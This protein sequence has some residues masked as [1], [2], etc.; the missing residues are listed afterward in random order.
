[1]NPFDVVADFES[2]MAEFT[3][4]PYA[5]AVDSC[6]S[7]LFLSMKY[8]FDKGNYCLNGSDLPTIDIPKRTFISVPQ[9][10][11]ESGYEK[12]KF[13]DFIWNGWYWL[14]PLP[15]IDSALHLKRDMWK[16]FMVFR[17][18]EPTFRGKPNPY[19]GGLTYACLSFQYRKH[20]PIGRGGMILHNDPEADVWFR[21]AR[22]YGRQACP[23]E[24]DSGPVFLGWR[25]YMTPDEAARGLCFM[26]TFPDNEPD[27][28]IKYP[29]LSGIPAFQPYVT[30]GERQ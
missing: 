25:K 6:T 9:Q 19:P 15:I 14:K 11:I 10:A 8:Q 28:E 1:M 17:D 13:V 21:L 5:V 3:G 22:F 20:I 16:E 26:H 29:P 7:A 4:A 18:D 24:D 2:C 12:I 27:L 23:L 30:T